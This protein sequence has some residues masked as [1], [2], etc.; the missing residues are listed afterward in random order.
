MLNAKQ[1]PEEGTMRGGWLAN[2]LGMG[3]E[4][5][6]CMIRHV[7]LQHSLVSCCGRQCSSIFV[8]DDC[9]FGHRVTAGTTSMVSLHALSPFRALDDIDRL[10]F[11]IG[12]TFSLLLEQAFLL[13]VKNVP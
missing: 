3:T 11:Q 10:C 4:L 1:H 9:R 13:F 5:Q 6:K 7:K 8:H 2:E 12:K